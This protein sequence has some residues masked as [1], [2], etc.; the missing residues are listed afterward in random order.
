[1]KWF[2]DIHGRQIRLTDEREEHIEND[3][4]EMSGQIDKCRE[5]LLNPDKVIRSRTDPEVELFYK[6][7]DVTSVT[8][9]FLCVVVKGLTN[10]LFIITTYFTDTVKRGELLWERK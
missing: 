3:H 5:T 6:Y 4:P 9:K 7:Y 2:K 10:N 8:K 1:M